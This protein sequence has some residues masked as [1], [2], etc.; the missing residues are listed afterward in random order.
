M[1]WVVPVLNVAYTFLALSIVTVHVVE[2][3][4]QS[5]DHPPKVELLAAVAV[6]VTVVPELNDAEQ[7]LP[8]FMPDG[9]LVTVPL[10]VPVLVTVRV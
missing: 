9:L 4:E 8:Q 6:T 2:V 10:P 7:V 3:P 1:H 5:P